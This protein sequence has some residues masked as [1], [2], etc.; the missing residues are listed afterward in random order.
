MRVLEE[1]NLNF[2]DGNEYCGG[3]FFVGFCFVFVF[4]LQSWVE[5]R[6]L[7]PL[8]KCHPHAVP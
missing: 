2:Y 4:V 6:A 8:G 5:A 1:T 7:G 3:G